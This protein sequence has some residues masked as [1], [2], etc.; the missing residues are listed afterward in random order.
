MTRWNLGELEKR[1]KTQGSRKY[2][3]GIKVSIPIN[4]AMFECQTIFL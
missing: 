1:K 2:T 4:H 3:F